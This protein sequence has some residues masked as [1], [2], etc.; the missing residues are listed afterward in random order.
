MKIIDKAEPPSLDKFDVED[1]VKLVAIVAI[2]D[3]TKNCLI[4]QKI[5]PDSI[6]GMAS[7]G[8]LIGGAIINALIFSGNNFFVQ[9]FV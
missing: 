9:Y 5:I 8:F 2:S 4:Q 7:V 6:Y 3:F 1:G